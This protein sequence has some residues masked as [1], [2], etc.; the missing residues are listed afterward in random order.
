LSSALDQGEGRNEA[1]RFVEILTNTLRADPRTLAI[2]AMRSDSFPLVQAHASLA[3]LPK[4]TFTLDMMLEGS[5][6]AVIEDPARLIQPTPLRIDPQLTEALL[7]EISG[8]YALPLLAFTLAHLYENYRGDNELTLSGY[9]KLG[10]VR[11]V[12]DTAVRQAFAEGVA[13]GELPKDAKVQLAL[14][15]AA[16]IPHLAQVNA[17]G[18]FTRSVATRDQ[19]PAEPRPLIDSFAE[20]RPADQRPPQRCLREGYRRRGGRAR[21]IAAPAAVQRVAGGGSRVPDR[22]TATAERSERLGGGQAG[23]QEGRTANPRASAAAFRR[24]PA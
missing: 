19:I 20:Q 6:R 23:G 10:R 7:K 14:A 18:Q 11:G 24:R 15:R 17:A 1:E 3:A 9:D 4:D 21:G 12:I 22:Q 5:Y 2:L 13:K 16:F 8:Q